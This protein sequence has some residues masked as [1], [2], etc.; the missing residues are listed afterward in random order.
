MRESLDE[1][2][3]VVFYF[4]S[5]TNL[6]QPYR[7]TWNNRDYLLGKVDFHHKTRAGKTLTHHF[8]LAD[9]DGTVYFKIALDT[10]NLHW[11]LEEYMYGSENNPHYG[12]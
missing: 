10:D 8:S 9:V 2:I 6:I 5:E 1:P 7:L 4:D 11:K 3:S 12:S